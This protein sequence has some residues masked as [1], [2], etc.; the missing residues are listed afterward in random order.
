MAKKAANPAAE[1]EATGIPEEG[2]KIRKL[3]IKN[4]GCIGATPVEID[5][6]D[7]VVLVGKNNTGKSTIL[8][9]YDVLF[10]SS[11]PKLV[12]EDFPENEVDPDNL[13]QIEL[14]TKVTSKP[15][16]NQ[17]IAEI[18]GENIIK[19]R[20]TFD[21]PA[22]AGRRQGYDVN[23]KAWSQQKPWG[24]SNVANARRPKPH[25]IH[26]FATPDESVQ[27]LVKILLTSLQTTMKNLP[28]TVTD[29]DGNEVKTSYGKL[30]EELG[31]I[32]TGVV[33]QVQ[34]QIDAVQTHLTDLVQKVFRGY[35]V[36]FE[37][38]PEED[39]T[40]CLTFFKPGAILRMGPENG[41]L[42]QAQH[43][44]S[45]ARRTLMWAALKYARE[46]EGVEGQ[47][48]LL[49]MDEPE[50]CLHPNA[51]REA[52]KTL[53]ELPLTGKW[54]VMLTTHSPAFID[55]SRDNTTVVRVERD[56][57]AD[58]IKGTTVF[59]PEKARLSN[60]EKI[61][62]KMLNLCDPSLCEFFFGGKTVI[63]EGDTEYTAFKYIMDKYSDDPRLHDV[64]IVRAR[65]KATIC[66]VA[67]I[68]NQFNAKYGILHDSD[69]PTCVAK[70]KNGQPYTRTN[71][72][73]TLNG[74]IC[75]AVKLALNEDR[76]R[77]VAMIPNFEAAFF[78]EEVSSDK[79]VNTW[80]KL[81][82][83]DVLCEKVRNLLYCLIDFDDA[84]P[85]ECE[86]WSDVEQL[87]KRWDAY[88]AAV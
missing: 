48:N 40:A 59:R 41:H 54:Q 69:S 79:P 43:Q 49:L 74:S 75:D 10:S 77:L 5:L 11:A 20:W 78:G 56:P 88:Q 31:D 67:K 76:T 46:H 37:A 33:A 22:L 72:A 71:T 35:K 70:K 47:Q 27:Q 6:D 14:H 17:W 57:T 1:E 8:R 13:P 55:L 26:A 9:A 2:A 60:D 62:L 65:G 18:D 82:A 50:L 44:G 34:E 87:V 66:L 80:K 19:E 30:L 12:L 21:G 51:V 38:K 68:L 86:D 36:A 3:V 7:I 83:S 24:W 63:V 15:P 64:H 28:R 32:R 42:S 4:F 53:Y 84:V 25:R 81:K 61:E 85:A 23:E 29:D 39:L 52:C 73:W 58:V 45:G 16:G